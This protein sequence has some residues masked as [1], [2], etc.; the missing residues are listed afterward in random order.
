M[1]T[2]IRPLAEGHAGEASWISV[3]AF[4]EREVVT[5]IRNGSNNLHLISW[6]TEPGDTCIRRGADSVDGP[7]I[8]PFQ[9]GEAREVALALM[10]RTAITAVRSGAGRL[11]LITWDVPEGLATM[12]RVWDSGTS[13]LEAQLINVV[14]VSDTILVT[15]CRAGNGDLLL[16]PWR[17]DWDQKLV[18]LDPEGVRAADLSLVTIVTMVRVDANNVVTA[19]RTQLG[20]LMLI[21]WSVSDSGEIKQWAPAPATAGLVSDIAL[22]TVG[23]DGVTTDLVTAVKNGNGNLLL[24]AWRLSPTEGTI[25]RLTPDGI[26]AGTADDISVCMGTTEPNGRPTIV[27]SMRRGSDNLEIITFELLTNGAGGATFVRTGEAENESGTDV[28][29]TSLAGLDPGRIVSAI[30]VDNDLQL[31]TYSLSA[32]GTTLIKPLAEESAGKA[33]WIAARAFNENEAVTALRNDSGNLELI[34]WLTAPGDFAI[35]R[36]ATNSDHDAFAAQEV[37]LELMG[38]SAI[39]A[40]RNED[41]RLQ[42]DV[43]SVPDGL[44]SMD[45]VSN[46]GDQAGKASNIAIAALSD[47]LLVTAVR[48][49]NGELL[50]IPWALES[51]QTLSRL[52]PEGV[53][54]RDD[55]DVSFVTIARVDANNVVTAVRN[56]NNLEVIGW[57]VSDAGQITQWS[58]S[59]GYAGVV[60]DIALATIGSSDGVTTDVVTAVQNGKGNLLLIAW[61]LSPADGKITRLTPDGFEGGPASAISVCMVATAP[62]GTPT[63]LTSMRRSF[64]RVQGQNIQHVGTDN[65]AIIAFELLP[66]GFGGVAFVRTG[67]LSNAA[68][69]KV[70]ETAFAPL[71]TGRVLSVLSMDDALPLTT[72]SIT[73]AVITPVPSTILELQYKNPGLHDSTDTSWAKSHGTYPSGSRDE[74][75]QVLAP[76]DDFE[77]TTL[78]G[79]AGWVVA[80][81][82]SGADMPFS[83]PFGF[84]W[85]FEIV[86]DDDAN[87]YQ[88]LLSPASSVG[89]DDPNHNPILLA[90]ALGISAPRGLLGM[91]WDKNLLPQSLRARV[92]HG[93]RVALLGR[94]IIDEGHDSSGFYRTEIHPPL[95]MATGS[96]EHDVEG[97]PFTRILFMSRPFLCGQ[98]YVEDA[99]DAYNETVDTDGSLFDHL[100]G[101]IKDLFSAD[102]SQIEVHPRIMPRPFQGCHHFEFTVRPPPLADPSKFELAVSFRFTTRHGC[103]MRVTGTADN[104]ISVAITLDSKGYVRPNLPARSEHS[105]FPDELD[106]LSPGAGWKTVLADAMASA[107]S[108]VTTW[109]T[110]SWI[111]AY[112]TFILFFRGIQTDEY[113]KLDEID[114]LDAAG[115]VE[116]ALADNIPAAQ[117]II[118]NDAQP[119]PFYG[120]MEARWVPRRG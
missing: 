93:D 82:M 10:G 99:D 114:I 4:N 52:D 48:A 118:S 60:A 68:N 39:T 100:I 92:D 88:D 73:D 7:P 18:R 111:G 63:I 109:W 15:A 31:K 51:N 97:I 119:Y 108:G 50:L 22:V 20:F 30:Q 87:G 78:V 84:D 37:S 70:V 89:G 74:W 41:D 2:L 120:W 26:E 1:P 21:G 90:N 77:T 103:R 43:W 24:I 65:L 110:G 69:T 23:T 101:Q 25:V 11:L 85:E 59:P 13:A 32:I 95:V 19:I 49:D 76:H 104:A 96:I 113:E 12:T 33:S 67:D 94:W 27:A 86:L 29:G 107:L 115:A 61:R 6:H 53:R 14:A 62:S 64:T 66:D 71:E 98:T 54:P 46:S 58:Q 36:A 75:V 102:S 112:V 57:S 38:R 35:A 44:A 83:H 47:T 17:L 106:T 34:G 5:A 8:P 28:T 45:W 116:N 80:P 79:T 16:I 91:E 105:Y 81:E 40:V 72:Y 117:G 56:R 55:T 3:Q 9:T 42:L